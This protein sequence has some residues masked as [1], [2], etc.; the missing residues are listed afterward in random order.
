MLLLLSSGQWRAD[1]LQDGGRSGLEFRVGASAD[2]ESSEPLVGDA[3]SG[4]ENADRDAFRLSACSEFAPDGI[5]GGGIEQSGIDLVRDVSFEAAHDVTVGELLRTTPL[6]VGHRPRL[7]MPHAQQHNPVQ[8]GVRVPVPA[9]RESMPC[10]LS[11]GGGD[12]GDTGE[13]GEAGAGSE[14]LGVVAGGDQERRCGDSGLTP[15]RRSSRYE[16]RPVARGR[17][18][19]DWSDPV[20]YTHLTLPTKA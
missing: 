18:Q 19:G 2:L 4:G 7:A 13:S 10:A 5:V 3:E 6:E 1:L 15:F 8:R 12:R 11:G 14:P 9:A 20:S 16:S 17:G